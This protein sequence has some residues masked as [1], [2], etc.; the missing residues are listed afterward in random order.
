MLP[1]AAMPLH[2]HHRH[3]AV[4]ALLLLMPPLC[5]HLCLAAN[6]AATLPATTALLP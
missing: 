6:T 1:A 5:R 4:A 3:A 2:C